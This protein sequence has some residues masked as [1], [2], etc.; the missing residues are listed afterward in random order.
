MA[1]YGDGGGKGAAI[2]KPVFGR[3]AV[4]EILLKFARYMKSGAVLDSTQIN[5]YEGICIRDGS[6]KALGVL[7]FEINPDGI[8]N[9]Y[10]VSNPDKLRHLQPQED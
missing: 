9:V 5:G 6:G 3:E 8:R 7:T 2:T 10:F 4:A 1:G